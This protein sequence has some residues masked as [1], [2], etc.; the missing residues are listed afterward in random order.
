MGASPSDANFGCEDAA[1]LDEAALNR[2]LV[3]AIDQPIVTCDST[4]RVV[5]MNA[6]ARQLCGVG[7]DAEIDEASVR[8]LEL[9]ERTITPG[10]HPVDRALAGEATIAKRLM[11]VAADGSVRPVQVNAARLHDA[12]GDPIGAAMTIWSCEGESAAER[13]L[14][15]F[16][17]D[18]E[19]LTEVSRLLSELHDP[20]E[21]AGIVC[22][23]ATGSTG[24]IAVLLWGISS[25]EL[26]IE[27]HEGAIEP[28]EMPAVTSP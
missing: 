14:V 15:N 2:A 23:V 17:S 19:I 1:E 26:E 6:A 27:R 5:T 8:M 11:L 16:A 24:A 12:A 18:I 25:G 20:D 7:E 21:A 22:M 10:T 28:A 13:R 4:G 3:E 9:D